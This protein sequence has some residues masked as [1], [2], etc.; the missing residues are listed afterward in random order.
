MT[1]RSNLIVFPKPILTLLWDIKAECDLMRQ[2]Y[3]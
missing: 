3:G 1:D 2:V